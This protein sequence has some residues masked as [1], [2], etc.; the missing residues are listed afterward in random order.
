MDAMQ[1]DSTQLKELRT[2]A[3]QRLGKKPVDADQP[4]DHYQHELHV[5]E[6]ELEMQ[7][8]ALRKAQGCLIES[9]DRYLDLYDFAPV[10]Y[11]TTSSSGII[12]EANLTFAKWL[13]IS[14][15]K[16]I[17]SP[18]SIYLQSE[19][20]DRWHT[21]LWSSRQLERQEIAEIGFQQADGM[22]FFA[23]LDCVS[24]KDADGQLKNRVSIVNLGSISIA[25]KLAIEG[26]RK[27]RTLYESMRDAFLIVDLSG[28]LLRSNQP[29]QNLLGYSAEELKCK[30]DQDLTPEKWHAMEAQIIEGQVLCDGESSVYEKEYIRKDGSIVPVELKAVLLKNVEGYPEHMWAVVRD[31]TNRKCA[32]AALLA[33]ESRYRLATKAISG[34]VYD[35]DAITNTLVVTEGYEKLLGQ[36]LNPRLTIWD[37]WK[38]Y[39]HPDD[40]W[41]LKKAASNVSVSR[42]ESIHAQFRIRHHDGRWLDV[43]TRTLIVYDQAG[44][45]VRLVGS[46][47]NE[48]RRVAAEA[49]LR[50][51]ND[52]LEEQVL[53]RGTELQSRLQQLH[54]SER[55]IRAT[56]DEVSV[57]IGVVDAEGRVIFKNKVWQELV[58]KKESCE[59]PREV[60]S[61]YCNACSATSECPNYQK[62]NA[63]L[64]LMLLGKRRSV[65]MEYECKGAEPLQR[66]N[67][68]ASRISRFKGDGPFRLVLSHENIT[69]RKLAANAVSQ[70]AK[71]FKAMLRKMEVMQQEHSKQIARE[72]HDQ[73]GATLTMLKLG[74]A[75]L[76][77][78]KEM[79]PKCSSKVTGMLELANMALK[80][81]K[82]VTASLRPS[83]LDTLGLSAAVNWHAKEFTRMTGIETDVQLPDL[84]RLST[85]DSETAFRIIQEALTNVAKHAKASKVV[86]AASKNKRFLN[87]SICDNGIGLDVNNLIRR[88]SFGVIGMQE[89]AKRLHGTIVFEPRKNGGSCL[90]LRIPFTQYTDTSE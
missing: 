68:I 34:F 60:Y 8:E 90:R 9:R 1:P 74:L 52:S 51:L 53:E 67:W 25:E 56:L 62:L 78:E 57:A 46:L 13:G 73:L 59:S 4:G 64:E 16:L 55:F 41:T 47:S 65:S 31:I 75:M 24:S 28:R 45:A 39:I 11:L 40:F 38:Q 2:L 79:S 70:S 87:I 14:R 30:T 71:N 50:T 5:H 20:K 80:S 76:Q 10:G 23:R 33:S 3:E 32:E 49:A 66:S 37:W 83:L 19:D 44:Q 81:V 12:E 72:V 63:A 48:S 69:E 86:I 89:R 77:N 42:P 21:L 58:H 17:G 7:N 15:R 43:S 54:E 61:P 22:R 88:N 29:F 18:C 6:I 27:Y 85:E 26:E 35:W 84:V 82:R 36:A